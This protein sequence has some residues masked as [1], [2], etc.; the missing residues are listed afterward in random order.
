MGDKRTKAISNVLPFSNL[1]YA[2]IVSTK[3]P[4]QLVYSIF[5]HQY[6][7]LLF[8]TFVIQLNDK[9]EFTYSYQNV[10]AKNIEEFAERLDPVDFELVE[11]ID[12]MT[13]DG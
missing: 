10:S 8:E 4:F 7:G 2:M 13:Q 3:Q 1:S 9:G 5:Q 12:D 11:I 6:L